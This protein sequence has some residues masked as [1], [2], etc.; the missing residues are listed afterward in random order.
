MGALALFFAEKVQR[1]LEEIVVNQ[2]N[3]CSHED[4]SDGDTSKLDEFQDAISTPLCPVE[5]RDLPAALDFNASI[6]HSIDVWHKAKNV[7]K[8][9]VIIKLRTLFWVL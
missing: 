5:V 2:R 6:R 4:D 8:Y 7:Q 3:G 1:A 9:R